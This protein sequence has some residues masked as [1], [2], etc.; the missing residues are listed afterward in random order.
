MLDLLYSWT[1]SFA[2]VFGIHFTEL[3]G[4]HD[5][6]LIV[7]GLVPMVVII[8]SKKLILKISCSFLSVFLFAI[9]LPYVGVTIEVRRIVASNPDFH[10]FSD[11]WNTAYVWFRYPLYWKVGACAGA[12]TTLLEWLRRRM[13]NALQ[14]RIW[15]MIG[16]VALLVT[17]RKAKPKSQSLSRSHIRDL[18]VIWR[19]LQN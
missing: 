12:L 5:L 15:F 8:F 11:S 18:C 16:R 6:L 2:D 7:I 10:F 13:K 19:N 17:F 14:Q 9:L 4:L 1:S 3:F